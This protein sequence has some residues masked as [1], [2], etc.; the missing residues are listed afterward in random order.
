LEA[1]SISIERIR[2]DNEITYRILYIITYVNNQDIPF[3][4]IAAAGLY[5]DKGDEGD[6]GE[7]GENKDRVVEAVTRLKE[8][9]FL[10]IRREGRDI[11]SYEM[12][13]LVQEATRYGLSMRNS[14]DEAYFSNAICQDVQRR[15]VNAF[16][17]LSIRLATRWWNL[18]HEDV[19]ITPQ[20]KWEPELGNGRVKTI[21]I[22]LP[23]PAS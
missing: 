14:D 20:H 15:G 16:G 1:W 11:R 23:F 12:H 8:F 19:R 5:D 13:K 2:R 21:D 9:S 3:E 4:I 22:H 18:Y 6:E 10:G 17:W 7:E